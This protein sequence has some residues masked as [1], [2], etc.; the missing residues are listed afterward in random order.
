M[1]FDKKPAKRTAEEQALERALADYEAHFGEP[2][3][4]RI[5]FGSSPSETI[6]DV[7]G[8]IEKDQRQTVGQYDPD[9]VY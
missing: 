6:K 3:V 2:Y 1:K 8:L 9:F 7:R 4:F 5:G